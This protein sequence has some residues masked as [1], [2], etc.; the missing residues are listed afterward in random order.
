MTQKTPEPLEPK[1]TPTLDDYFT[2]RQEAKAVVEAWLTWRNCEKGW[3]N[4]EFRAWS[5]KLHALAKTLG[6]YTED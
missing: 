1:P 6:I 5:E 2:L 3:I 4:D